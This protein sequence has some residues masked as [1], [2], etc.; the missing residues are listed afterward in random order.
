VEAFVVGHVGLRDEHR[1]EVG[2]GAVHV[3]GHQ[4]AALRGGLLGFLLVANVFLF[5]AEVVGSLAHVLTRREAVDSGD[6]CH[7]H[8]VPY[9]ELDGAS[10][11]LV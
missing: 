8:V 7:A 11:G 9:S 5:D 2:S 1:V 3:V 10:P 6:D 4:V